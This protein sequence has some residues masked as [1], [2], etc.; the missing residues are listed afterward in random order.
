[1]RQM[2]RAENNYMS[3]TGTLILND[4][5]RLEEITDTI[6]IDPLPDDF[7]FMGHT[8]PLHDLK[9]LVALIEFTRNCDTTI[10]LTYLEVGSWAGISA[11]MAAS[12][13]NVEV[14][15][16]DHWEGESGDA[17]IAQRKE[18]ASR[19]GSEGAF[20]VFKRNT[21]GYN[22]I[23]HRGSSAEWSKKWIG[24]QVDV[25]FIDADHSYENVLRDC[26]CWLPHVRQGGILC[27]HDYNFAEVHRAVKEFGH[28]ASIWGTVWFRRIREELGEYEDV[29]E[30]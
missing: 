25:L 10:P 17:G 30:T 7:N 3:A 14:H 18:I 12:R 23:P 2:L 16:V 9:S 1:M 13:P 29:I 24:K 4:L 20:E 27:G 15:C 11:I 8:T 26:K 21:A 5:D 28:D 19:G 6:E 22:I